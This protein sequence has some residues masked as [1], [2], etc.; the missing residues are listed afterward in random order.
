[1]LSVNWPSIADLQSYLTAE[2]TVEDNHL[3]TFRDYHLR[4]NALSNEE[5]RVSLILYEYTWCLTAQLGL[6]SC[7]RENSLG[8]QFVYR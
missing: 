4:R 7:W 1:M 2:N 5:L 8:N 3:I 6:F